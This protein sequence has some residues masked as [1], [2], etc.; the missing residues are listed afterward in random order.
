MADLTPV[1][2]SIWYATLASS[3]TSNGTVEYT[4]SE[5]INVL[6]G[7]GLECPVPP[8]GGTNQ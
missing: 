7:A 3:T 6:N 8:M 5:P 2:N 4:L 1:R